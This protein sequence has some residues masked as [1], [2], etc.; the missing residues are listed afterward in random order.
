[1][2]IYLLFFSL[3]SWG[4]SGWSSFS[5]IISFGW[6][7]AEL[8][9]CISSSQWFLGPDELLAMFR[10]PRSSF[11]CWWFFNFVLTLRR[12]FFVWWKFL[13]IISLLQA[14]SSIRKKK[15]NFYAGS[16]SRSRQQMIVVMLGFSIGVI[17]LIYLGCP[18]F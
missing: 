5:V 15:S 6:R 14:N 10:Y 13:I 1:M 2:R 3:C 4:S 7:G 18:I 9:T 11:I 16:M 12:M 17:P 8:I